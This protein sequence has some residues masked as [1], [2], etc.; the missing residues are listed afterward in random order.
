MKKIF[1]LLPIALI[2]VF[3]ATQAAEAATVEYES[4]F[5]G[6]SQWQYNYTVTNDIS[7]PA[8]GA[9]NI[10][11]GNEYID[12]Q[13]FGSPADSM[14]EILQPTWTDPLSATWA[15]YDWG[16]EN[17]TVLIAPGES[18]GGFSVQFNWF[19]TTDPLGQEFEIFDVNW[20]YLGDGFATLGGGTQT[21][22]I[23]EPGTLMLF[24]MGL[25]GLA[26]YYRTRKTGKR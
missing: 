24:G 6:G 22:D 3:C 11:F 2:L 13:I 25:A 14:G 26:A 20:G 21:P 18:L 15:G 4:T 16:I 19:G 5:L 10:L 7:A 12:L 9:I 23:P 8:I 1:K 17:F